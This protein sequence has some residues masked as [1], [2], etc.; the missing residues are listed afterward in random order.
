MACYFNTCNFRGH[1]ILIIFKRKKHYLIGLFFLRTALLFILIFL[2]TFF[3]TNH[4]VGKSTCGNTFENFLTKLKEEAVSK[5]HDI[6]TVDKFFAQATLDPKVLK[7]DRS[8]TIFR[9]SF[10]EFSR[11]V[12]STH[13]LQQAA[14][15]RKRFKNAFDQIHY[16][17]GIPKEI[18]LTFWALETDF[19]LF[20][21]EY[22]TLNALL[23]LSH[24]CRRPSLF[25]PQI[26][27]ALELYT[28]KGFDPEQTKGAWAGEV[29][30]L[31]MLP[32]DLLEYGVDGDNDGKID[33]RTSAID[34]LYST[35]RKLASMGWKR[36]EPWLLEVRVPEKMD[37]RKT[38]LDTTLPLIEWEKMGVWPRL[39]NFQ[40]YDEV[41]LI[42]PMGRKGPAFLIYPN[43][44]VL[45][46]WNNSSVYITT[47]A[48]FATL[49]NG[50]PRYR[51]GSPQPI[52]SLEEM[53]MLQKKLEQKGY[54][55]G[56]VDG[57]LGAKTR[58]A[59]K[60]EQLRMKI[61]ADGW[62]TKN[63]LNKI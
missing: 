47:A 29:G 24:D 18:L 33:I 12:I 45:S 39:G 61:P 48:Y 20:Q 42:L 4:V 54:D 56:G 23:T 36:D 22:N 51:L 38:G 25:R 16:I 37:W 63:M 26:F 27:A 31:Q 15:N 28:Q 49:L 21:G 62:P 59:V 34:A 55:V 40:N 60:Q 43:F 32:L 3:T 17:Y 14:I 2:S 13:R 9:K 46:K 19:G 57:I 50:E 5:G 6:G 35:A 11:A 7:A 1:F 52:L 44:R 53:V 41:S 30:M 8:Q 58:K 10:F